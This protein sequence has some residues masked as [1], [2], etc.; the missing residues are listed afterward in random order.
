[1][2]QLNLIKK[3]E[4]NKAR[5]DLTGISKSPEDVK[6]LFDT[7]YFVITSYSIHYTKLYEFSMK[8]SRKQKANSRNRAN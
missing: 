7:P 6:E 8:A 5:T 3:T 1:M 2:L 4:A